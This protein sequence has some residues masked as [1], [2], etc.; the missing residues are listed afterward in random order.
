VILG[1]LACLAVDTHVATQL[2]VGAAAQPFARPTPSVALGITA[3][4]SQRLKEIV[5]SLL[6]QEKKHAIQARLNEVLTAITNLASQPNAQQYQTAA[7]EA[8]NALQTAVDSLHQTLSP[9]QVKNIEEIGAAPY[10]SPSMVGR[11]REQMITNAM[12]PAVVQQSV[13]DW[14]NRRNNFITVLTNLSR[15]LAAVGI[16]TDELSPGD[17]EV[18]I[19]F[20]SDLF[21]NDLGGLIDELKW[22]HRTFRFFQEVANVGPGPITVRQISTSDPT[23]FFGMDVTSLVLF[24]LAAKWLVDVLKGTLDI[25]Q[26]ITL[27]RKAGFAND[28]IAIF[29]AEMEQRIEAAVSK[30][31]AEMLADFRGD[32]GRK[33]ELEAG[34]TKSVT[35]LAARIERGMTI[36]IRCLPPPIDEN[37]AAPEDVARA[38]QF[39]TLAAVSQELEFPKVEGQPVLQLGPAEPEER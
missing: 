23:F 9:A 31:V 22:L 18:G 32:S 30:R 38:G 25:K 7:A 13:Q 5:D 11:I 34:L 36:E 39:Q 15:D 24:G 33:N 3:M 1:A 37:A 26:I 29:D 8:I 2:V 17:S 19:R 20:P 4:N 12:T 28:K 14:V 16:Q 27:A 6:A 21:G 10:F 35:G